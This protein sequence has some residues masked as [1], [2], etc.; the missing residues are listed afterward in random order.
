MQNTSKL[1]TLDKA[2]LQ[3]LTHLQTDGR[4]SVLELSKRVSLSP[5]P[6]T[7]RMRKLEEMGIIKGYHARLDAPALGQ[8]LMIFVTVKLRTTEEATLKKF[9]AAV[10]PIKQILECHMVGG[11]FDYLLKV[12]V[13][14]MSEYR[15]ILGGVIGSLPMVEGTHSYFVMEAVK[16]SPLI[17]IPSLKDKNL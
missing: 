1:A 7:Q 4:L 9:N 3:I 17:A 15:E 14:D 6:C 8:A 11:G 16:D 12:R 10:K 5:T 13:R 2:D